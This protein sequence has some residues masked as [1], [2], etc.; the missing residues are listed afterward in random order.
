MREEVEMPSLFDQ[1][2]DASAQLAHAHAE[3]NLIGVM[4]LETQM[5]NLLDTL[6]ARGGNDA[7][8]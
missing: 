2:Y 7:S 6:S 5:N 8:Q 1:L 4:D 3:G